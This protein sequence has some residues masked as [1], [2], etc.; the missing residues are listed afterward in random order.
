[1][2][3]VDEER[4]I[5]LNKVVFRRRKTSFVAERRLSLKKDVFLVFAR[6]GADVVNELFHFL[7]NHAQ[8]T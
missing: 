7:T 5:S 2:M 3:S 8:R 6:T 1:M 4:R